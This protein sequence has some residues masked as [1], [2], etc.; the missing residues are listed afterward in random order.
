MEIL[1]IHAEKFDGVLSCLTGCW[2]A[3]ISP[4]VSG[5]AMYDFLI[6]EQITYSNRCPTNIGRPLRRYRRG[7]HT[8]SGFR[9][10][11]IREAHLKRKTTQILS[12]GLAKTISQGLK[13]VQA[14]SYPRRDRK[15]LA[16]PTMA[17]VAQGSRPIERFS[18]IAKK[19]FP[20]LHALASTPSRWQLLIQLAF[21]RS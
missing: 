8:I 2:F 1:A 20:V 19:P 16:C 18:S 6:Q 4:S 5:A 15:N 14:V 12:R 10:R 11:D 21:Q 3:A 17:L 9:N 13:A 7:A